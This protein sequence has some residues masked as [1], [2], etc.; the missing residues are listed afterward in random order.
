MQCICIWEPER[1]CTIT[2]ITSIELLN[3]PQT[4][5]SKHCKQTLPAKPKPL[6]NTP[7]QIVSQKN[8]KN[9]QNK[10][11]IN[12]IYPPPTKWKKSQQLLIQLNVRKTS[13]GKDHGQTKAKIRL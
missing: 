1:F 2:Q 7:H 3:N 5:Q 9:K 13:L 6:K 11:F 12:E 8:K 10:P 4:Q